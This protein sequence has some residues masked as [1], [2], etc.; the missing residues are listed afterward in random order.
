MSEDMKAKV[1]KFAPVEIGV[2]NERIPA[3][4]RPVIKKLVDAARMLDRLFLHQVAKENPRW[5]EQIAKD[6]AQRDTLAYFDIMYGPWDRLDHN[7]P[8][9]GTK[10]KPKGATFYPEDLTA[11]DLEA[12]IEAHPDK[13][14]AVTGYFTVIE[15]EGGGLGAAPYNEAYRE[16][17]EPAGRLLEE[18]AAL[19]GDARLKTY[20][21]KRARAF[22][23][24]DYRDSDMAWM[25]LGDGALEVVIGPYEVYEDELMGW[26][27]AFESFVTLRD[28]EESSKL[29]RI[30]TL[31]PDMEKN[32]PIPDEYKNSKRG[33][34]SP[35]SVVEVLFTAGDTRAGVQT[36][37]FNL[38]NDEV[39][40]EK[41]GSKKVMLKNV[42][43]AKH[44][45]ILIP[46]AREMMLAAQ[47]GEVSFDAFFNHTLLHEMAH[48]LGPGTITVERDGRKIETTVNR[49]LRDL[50]STIEEAKADTLGLF[51][52]LYLVD[53]GFFPAEFR[54][55]VYATLVA[56]FFRSVRF[57][58]TE[59]HG[60]ANVIQFNY[61]LE[62]GGVVKDAEGRYGYDAAKM[63]GAV[64]SLT[65]D[66]LMIEAKGDYEAAKA[67]IGKYGTLSAEVVKKLSGLTAIPTDIRPTY[68]VE[69]QMEK[70]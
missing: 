39:V 56:G 35:L 18:A 44:D 50:Y 34:E 63:P 55:H 70:W 12:W 7:K 27:A 64:R 8:F 29:D 20:L 40:R 19:T 3:G 21:A 43:R 13:K 16:F 22:Q 62:K 4:L 17:L 1:A 68:T 36:S 54:E 31:L 9:W 14:D 30:K 11:K 37:A 45:K 69:K 28:P 52:T 67:F 53:R 47:A 33:S 58:A 46:I 65:T 59:A 57:G 42:I 24:N 41:K 60:R 23:A 49:E 61:L 10:E 25:D 32:L 6:P 66:L 48:G 38:P 5:R 2:P 26:K 15:R 51:E